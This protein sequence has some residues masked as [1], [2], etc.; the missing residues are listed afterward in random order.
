MTSQPSG[1]AAQHLKPYLDEIDRRRDEERE[2]ARA[3]IAA[4]DETLDAV[5]KFAETASQA[6]IDAM[7]RDLFWFRQELR[8]R[9]VAD[10]LGYKSLNEMIAAVG[11][12][13]TGKMCPRCGNELMRVT[14]PGRYSFQVPGFE[15]PVCQECRDEV[16]AG[17][18]F[19]PRY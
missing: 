2:A 5:R 15:D 18:A 19:S 13:A 1:I 7:A 12:F 9:H 4:Q 16:L 6:D 8:A 11:P 10:A 14:A 3:L 17:H